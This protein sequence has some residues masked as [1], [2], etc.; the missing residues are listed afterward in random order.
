MAVVFFFAWVVFFCMVMVFFCVCIGWVV[1]GSCM[2]LCIFFLVTGSCGV[3]LGPCV[4]SCSSCRFYGCFCFSCHRCICSCSCHLC[5]PCFHGLCV[6]VGFC[7][8]CWCV[9]LLCWWFYFLLLLV[10]GGG[11]YTCL[12]ICSF[13][14]GGIY[15]W[16]YGHCCVFHSILFS[17]GRFYWGCLL[18]FSVLWLRFLVFQW[19]W[20]WLY[21]L[22]L[23]VW[24]WWW[25]GFGLLFVFFLRLSFLL[26]VQWGLRLRW[27]LLCVFVFCVFFIVSCVLGCVEGGVVFWCVHFLCL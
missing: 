6:W 1:V 9:L 2:L 13:P 4:C 15:S 12:R 8:F 27:L 20:W 3:V 17:P 23:G 21:F 18:W 19:L 16:F 22:R 7:R 24:F 14:F 5:S 10:L 26:Y 25:L 11:I